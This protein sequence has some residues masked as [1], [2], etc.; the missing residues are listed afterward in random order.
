MVS[1]E[2]VKVR[3]EKLAEELSFGMEAVVELLNEYEMEG[4]SDVELGKV[5]RVLL[6]LQRQYDNEV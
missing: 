2:E 4:M 5:A 6:E 3:F 1:R